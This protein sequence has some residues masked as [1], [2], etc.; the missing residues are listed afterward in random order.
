VLSGWGLTRPGAS[1]Y[2]RIISNHSYAHDEQGD[3]P[4]QEKEG[5]TVSSINCN[6][7][8]LVMSCLP[9]TPA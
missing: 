3:N 5:L 9:A 7:L 2:E 1:A 6:H 8:D 4:G